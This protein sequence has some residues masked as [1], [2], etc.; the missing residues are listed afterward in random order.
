MSHS[1]RG[2]PSSLRPTLA[3][4]ALAAAA[5][6]RAQCANSWLPLGSGA[7][8]DV[9][10][11]TSWDPDGPGPQSAVMVVGGTFSTIG[12]IFAHGVAIHDPVLGTW[13]AT[14]LP[15]FAFAT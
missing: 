15:Q 13:S 7:N 2:R 4:I 5:H 3:M 9:R 14:G 10:A 6:V 11:M 8:G 1:R 12:G